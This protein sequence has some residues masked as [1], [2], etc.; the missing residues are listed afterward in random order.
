MTDDE[1]HRSSLELLVEEWRRARDATVVGNNASWKELAD[2]ETALAAYKPDVE[3]KHHLEKTER[4]YPQR[5]VD[6]SG[7]EASDFSIPFDSEEAATAQT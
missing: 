2:A 4:D 3:I 7:M 6:P 5:L 1:A